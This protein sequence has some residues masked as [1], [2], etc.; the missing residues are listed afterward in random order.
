[1]SV[2][3]VAVV[4]AG[5]AGSAAALN[6]LRLRPDATVLL[7]DAQ[8]FPRDKTCGDGVAAEVFDLLDDLGVRGVRDLGEPAQRLRLR[9]PSGRAVHRTAPRPNR[10][11]TRR[12]FDAALVDAAVAAGAELRRH[13]VRSL[14][15]DGDRVV[16]DGGGPGSSGSHGPLAARTVIGADGAHSA[17]RRALGAPPAPPE[18]TA[19]AIRGYAPVAAEPGTL[20]IEYAGDTYPAYAWSFPVAG[21]GANVGYGVFDKRGAGTRAEF[22]DRI[23]ALLPGQ[24]PYPETLRA[25]HL[26][27]STTPRFQPDGRVLLAGDAAAKVNPLTG[28]GIFDAVASGILAG[29]NALRGADAGA[30]HRAAMEHT[31]G[32]HHRHVA[33]LARLAARPAFLDAAI[34]AASAHRSVFDCAVRLGLARGVVTPSALALVAAHLPGSAL[35]AGGVIRAVRRAAGPAVG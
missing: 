25:H 28:E 17:V 1:M 14:E 16:L 34:G 2:Y 33:A 30:A 20:T 9:T 8:P 7:L 24:Q 6:V 10:V 27:L 3:D 11:I 22:L 19:V 4:G 26:P 21:G 35:R 31:F 15:V 18:G 12:V 23:A 13:R 32:R 5:P 29:R